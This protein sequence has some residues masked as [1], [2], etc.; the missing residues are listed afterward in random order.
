MNFFLLVYLRYHPSF[1]FLLQVKETGKLKLEPLGSWDIQV[2]IELSSWWH[3]EFLLPIMDS[4]FLFLFFHYQSSNGYMV[5]FAGRK[6]AARSPPIFVADQQ[7]IVTSFT[8]VSLSIYGIESMQ[9]WFDPAVN[10]KH[11]LIKLRRSWVWSM[12]VKI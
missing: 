4:W 7:H 5:A 11:D 8:L 6:Y 9:W 10:R 12:V 2:S 1:G 3:F